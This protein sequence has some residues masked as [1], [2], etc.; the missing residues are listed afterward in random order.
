MTIL[1]AYFAVTWGFVGTE[2][3]TESPISAI[4]FIIQGNRSIWNGSYTKDKEA[5]INA[6]NSNSIEESSS[7]R[8]LR[9]QE[10]FYTEYSNDQNFKSSPLADSTKYS[11]IA[12]SNYSVIGNSSE[13]LLSQVA[14]ITDNTFDNLQNYSLLESSTSEIGPYAI[15]NKDELIRLEMPSKFKNT[16]K[17]MK[18]GENIDDEAYYDTDTDLERVNNA[19]SQMG[20]SFSSDGEDKN[21]KNVVRHNS[22]NIRPPDQIKSP[23]RPRFSYGQF[24]G[25]RDPGEPQ[26]YENYEVEMN[27]H[28][29]P[30]HNHDILYPHHRPL[31]PRSVLT[32]FHDNRQFKKKSKRRRKMFNFQPQTIPF[33]VHPKSSAFNKDVPPPFSQ[34]LNFPREI[35]QFQNPDPPFW[36]PYNQDHIY[37]PLLPLAFNT[38]PKPSTPQYHHPSNPPI[39]DPTLKFKHFAPFLKCKSNPLLFFFNKHMCG[40]Q[41]N[42]QP[43]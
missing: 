34:D 4:P 24:G 35:Q 40:P 19:A 37:D 13:N 15:Y 33:H 7:N 2:D 43:F 38:V 1:T 36:H 6:I 11:R 14:N 12:K 9:D 8:Q 42:F 41:Y 27:T 3:E 30:P 16:F 18:V 39:H 31:D 20:T 17:Q 29:R 10:I 28:L 25:P 22:R 23:Y 21:S 5:S 26:H 32:P